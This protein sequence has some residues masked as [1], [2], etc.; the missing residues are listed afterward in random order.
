MHICSFRTGQTGYE[1][2]EPRAG[3][4]VENCQTSCMLLSAAACPECILL[5][6][7]ACWIYSPMLYL[8]HRY[9]FSQALAVAEAR[10]P[11]LSKKSPLLHSY[12]DSVM[13]GWNAQ[14]S[15]DRRRT[16]VTDR[17]RRQRAGQS[18]AR[19]PKT[20]GCIYHYRM[21]IMAQ[22]AAYLLSS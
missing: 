2:I 21:Y 14:A 3:A 9:P 13:D 6:A 18:T 5:H 8:L 10:E 7:K 20:S 1:L 17:S 19:D 12:S 15:A 11:T 22:L 16:E 4:A